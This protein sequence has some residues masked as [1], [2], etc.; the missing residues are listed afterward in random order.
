[1]NPPGRFLA[2]MDVKMMISLNL[3]TVE[4]IK[5][6]QLQQQQ[7]VS[8]GGGGNGKTKKKEK[9]FWYD[10][11]DKKAREKASQ[12]LRER[13]GAANEAVAALV[14]T[15]TAN[16]EACPEDYATL[17]SKAAKLKEAQQGQD[18]GFGMQ[19]Q[20]Q[21]MNMYGGGGMGGYGGGGGNGGNMG[22]G[23]YGGMNN[24]GG[25][26]VGYCEPVVSGGNGINNVGVGSGST[27]D[28]MIEAEIQRLLREKQEQKMMMGGGGGG[29]NSNN[30]NNNMGG[31]GGGGSNNNLNAHNNFGYGGDVQPY[32]GEESVLREYQALIQK[33]QE[34][35]ARLANAKVMMSQQQQ[36]NNNNHNNGGGGGGMMSAPYNTN[37]MG[38]MMG[39]G[40][41]SHYGN[42]QQQQQ[43][44]QAPFMQDSPQS[45][46]PNNPNPNAARDYMNRLRML[47]Q[48]NHNIDLPLQ[49]NN[50]MPENVQSSS[51]S[52][53]NMGGGGNGMNNMN[54][55]NMGGGGSMNMGGSN[56]I[57]NNM[58]GSNGMN[59]MG[60]GG[61]MGGGGGGVNSQK[62]FSIEE[63][64][65]SLQEFL[66]H[67]DGTNNSGGGGGGRQHSMAS[68]ATQSFNNT[69]SNTAYAAAGGS[70][71]AIKVPTNLND[72]NRRSYTRRNSDRSVDDIDLPIG[73]NTFKSVDSDERPSFQSMDDVG[74]GGIRDTFRSVDTMDLMS[75]G[76]SLNEIVEE[77]IKNDSDQ[78]KK[79]SRRLSATSLHSR[80]ARAAPGGAATLSDYA[81]L[82]G[83]T[84]EVKTM[85]HGQGGGGGPKKIKKAIDPR[86]VAMAGRDSGVRGTK[87]SMLSQDLNLEG[88]D[89]NERMSFGNFSI[90]SGL[91]DFGDDID[92]SN[93]KGLGGD[94][95]E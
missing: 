22:G 95:A 66:Y 16:G 43:Q 63:Y 87:S 13:N 54:M 69:T 72:G 10:V 38:G 42:Q 17:M 19:Q 57:M 50:G 30:I 77:D 4:E 91:T 15:V 7:E 52:M 29:N 27:E 74:I 6:E 85:N 35:D 1:M 60:G 12:C 5:E 48:G 59:T 41:G 61:N 45:M 40:G 68:Q 25:G 37:N 49:Y 94:N 90:M 55:T 14:K 80:Y 9:V 31:R 71:G 39:G 3:I 75:I 65:A 84:V 46:S 18:G 23:G 89:D 81:H 86:L 20:Q 76:A 11:G 34:L 21:Q 64:Q 78:R 24:M 73:R 51:G 88:I 47:R 58:G 33:Q 44:Q 70:A 79:N 2:K 32:M 28:D 67:D 83:A 36:G 92:V 82:P 62:E 93:V 56:G 53:N 26:N 8:G